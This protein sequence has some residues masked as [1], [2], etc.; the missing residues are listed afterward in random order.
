MWGPSSDVVGVG[1]PARPLLA[2]VLSPQQEFDRVK[3]DANI[4]LRAGLVQRYQKVLG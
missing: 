1:A 4:L 3:A 2:A